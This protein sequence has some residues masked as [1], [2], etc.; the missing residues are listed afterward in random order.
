MITRGHPWTCPRPPEKSVDITTITKVTLT[1]PLTCGF[2]HIETKRFISRA[3][4]DRRDPWTCPRVSTV[5]G[6]E[7]K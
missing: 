3:R 2:S 7:Q 1:Y 5:Y 4:V 6:G